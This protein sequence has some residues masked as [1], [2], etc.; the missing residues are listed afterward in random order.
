MVDVLISRTIY[1]CH[2]NP[3]P[4]SQHGNIISND[5]HVSKICLQLNAQTTYDLY[6]S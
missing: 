3:N 5:L 1:L 6:E 2:P 4:I